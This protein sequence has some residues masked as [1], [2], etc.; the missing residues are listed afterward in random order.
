M[1]TSHTWRVIIPLVFM[2]WLVGCTPKSG[3]DAVTESSSGG[4]NHVS[5]EGK[6]F[7]DD[8]GD[9]ADEA[10]AHVAV[11]FANTADRGVTSSASVT[12]KA[13][14]LAPS[15]IRFSEV[16]LESGLDFTYDNGEA[17]K[18][19]MVETVGGGVGVLDY[20]RDGTPD[21]FFCQGGDPTTDDNL[22]R[23]PSTLFRNAPLG[24]FR[25]VGELAGI[26]AYGYGQGVA[27]GDFN[28]DG[29]EDVYLTNVGRNVLLMNNGDGTFQDITASSGTGDDLWSTSAAFAD[30][31]GDGLL[32][33]YV[34]NY[35]AYNPRSPLNC[36]NSKGEYRICHPREL[37]PVPDHFYVNL[38]DGTFREESVP[39]E[40]VGEGN[41]ALGV[42]VA[43]FN[44]DGSPDVYVANDTTANFLFLN[45]GDGTFQ[46]RAQLL[47]CAANYE[48]LFQASMG[49]AI[50][51]YDRNG[52]LDIYSTHFYEESNTL[53]RNLG[54]V[55]FQDVTGSMG[56]HTPTLQSLG[57]GTAMADFDQDG[58]LD[59]F[60]TNGHVENY[61]NNPIHK[62]R[63]QL[64]QFDGTRWYDRSLEAGPFFHEKFVGRG[65]ASVDFDNDG[66]L[67][68][69][70]VHQNQRT[71][72]LRN[73]SRRGNWIKV[74]FVGRDSPRDG[75]G[76][77]VRVTA[78]D[79]TYFHELVG[80]GSYLSSSQ[81]AIVFGVGEFDG[82]C[83]IE[84]T[85][86]TG[87]TSRFHQLV[88]Q[89]A[90]VT[91]AR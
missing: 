38:G 11:P 18:S 82:E 73:D 85:W 19:L 14:S 33:I 79:Q 64:F 72:L 35:L 37:P 57:F 32:D 1:S 51:D 63:P 91:E 34:C 52:L 71:A 86:P 59:I 80:G 23:P 43:D 77:R 28:A 66:D 7:G 9:S 54:A 10:S 84:V 36:R 39:R 2:A 42:A 87:N 90:L 65:V 4:D 21:L 81:S 6:L 83:E 26:G 45:R 20:D 27:I 29:F 89:D 30:L 60:V 44:V 75:T 50:G 68:L 16:A 31:T 13:D 70:V 55:G 88:N 5:R 56:L 41:K 40:L 67:D 74:V 8:F 47:G 12:D 46:E 24:S 3:S 48:G 62:M 76:C 58:W 78:G 25:N 17:G 15:R 61:P 69:V 49:L 22:H 53:Y